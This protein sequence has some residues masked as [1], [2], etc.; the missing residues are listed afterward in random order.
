VLIE[1]GL[2]ALVWLLAL[3]AGVSLFFSGAHFLNRSLCILVPIFLGLAWVPAFW[4]LSSASSER[5]F[6][7]ALLCLPLPAAALTFA[8]RGWS[9]LAVRVN[10]PGSKDVWWL[11]RPF[12]GISALILLPSCWYATVATVM[13]LLY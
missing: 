1:L 5:H 10:R 6:W 4:G 9:S 3:V 2:V 11:N 7:F 8:F 12:M 13:V